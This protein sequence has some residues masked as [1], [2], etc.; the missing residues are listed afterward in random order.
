MQKYGKRIREEQTELQTL[1]LLGSIQELS[2]PPFL[3]LARIL[4]AY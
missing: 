2:P 4:A 3:W 1:M